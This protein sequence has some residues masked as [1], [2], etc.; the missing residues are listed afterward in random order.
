MKTVLLYNFSGERLQKAKAAVLLARAGARVV[1]K[2]SY[3]KRLGELVGAKGYET[4]VTSEYRDFDEEL[5]VMSGFDRGDIDRLIAALRQTGVGRVALK[6]VVTPTNI[7]WNS[8]QLFYAVKA[9][10]EEM[11]RGKS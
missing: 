10:H 3:G 2:D 5:L 11:H 9:D 8:S 6:A 1:E 7:D 4:E